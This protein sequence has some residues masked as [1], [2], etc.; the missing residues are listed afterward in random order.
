M[1]RIAAL[2]Y[3]GLA[4]DQET[5]QEALKTYFADEEVL[6]TKKEP[7]KKK[8]AKKKA[9]KT[10]PSDTDEKVEAENG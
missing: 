4:S 1:Q 3:Q 2:W 7:A 8:V 10:K 6:Q 5:S 9:V